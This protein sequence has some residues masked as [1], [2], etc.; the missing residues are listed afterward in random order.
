M[1]DTGWQYEQIGLGW[2]GNWVVIW[3][4]YDGDFYQ[5]IE[6]I[7]DILNTNPL[8]RRA[9]RKMQVILD[10]K[11]KAYVSPDIRAVI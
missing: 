7:P 9:A 10:S 3:S 8:R 4:M 5:R 6:G 2:S 11:P 1:I